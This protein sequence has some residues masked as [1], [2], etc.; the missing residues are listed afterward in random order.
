[1]ERRRP[2]VYIPNKSHHDFSKAEEYGDL[3][4]LTEGLVK[5]LNVN[6][7]YR[8][9]GEIM[10]D[11]IEEDYILVSSLSILNAIPASIM[12]YKFG[13]VNYLLHKDGT[14]LERIIYL[15]R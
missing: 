5:R 9:I 13:R 1:M 7:L 8:E 14:Y 12:A 3:V 6:A 11:A 15:G 2:R 4:F 10:E